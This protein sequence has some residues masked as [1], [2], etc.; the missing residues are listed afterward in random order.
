ML[1]KYRDKEV[2]SLSG[3][4]KHITERERFSCGHVVYRGIGNINYDLVPSIGRP[5]Y[6]NIPLPEDLFKIH[7]E[8]TIEK[9][10]IYLQEFKRKGVR[11]LEQL[12]KNQMEWLFIAQHHGL[13]TR[14]LDWSNSPLVALFFALKDPKEADKDA[15]IYCIHFCNYLVIDD[16]FKCDISGFI[17]PDF[18][19]SRISAQQSLFSIQS[20]PIERFDDLISRDTENGYWMQRIIIPSKSKQEIS[21]SLHKIGIRRSYILPDLDALSYDIMDGLDNFCCHLPVNHD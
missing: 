19:A 14:L 13:K 8:D 16:P 9:E 18:I 5:Y 3:Y 10:K 11:F 2:N 17:Y 21:K 4:I 6:R 1:K 15:V 12:P 20:N 7:L